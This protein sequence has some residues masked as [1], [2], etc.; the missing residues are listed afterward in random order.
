MHGNMNVKYYPVLTD[1]CSLTSQIA[2][3]VVQPICYSG[4]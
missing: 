4:F 1:T 3:N 2:S